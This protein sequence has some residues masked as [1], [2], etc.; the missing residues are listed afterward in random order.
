MSL[1]GDNHPVRRV[2]VF[3]GRYTGCSDL[4]VVQA[5]VSHTGW[6]LVLLPV[7]PAMFIEGQVGRP[8]IG[9]IAR[10][11]DLLVRQFNGPFLLAD[12]MQAK[13]ILTGVN[14]AHA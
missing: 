6:P 10:F 1:A 12:M 7:H 13:A 9:P 4:F 5:F 14:H 8:D 3:D 11:P 2:V